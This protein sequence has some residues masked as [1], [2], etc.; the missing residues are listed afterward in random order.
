MSGPLI[1]L[2]KEITVGIWLRL[3]GGS[4]AR[5]LDWVSYLDLAILG[6]ETHLK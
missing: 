3:V 2:P 4:V 5:K 1:Q 6:G